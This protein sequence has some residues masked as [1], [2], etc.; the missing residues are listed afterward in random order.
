MDVS[1]VVEIV[2]IVFI[3]SETIVIPMIVVIVITTVPIITLHSVKVVAGMR[4]VNERECI[5]W[6]IG[7]DTKTIPI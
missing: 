2:L 6:N 1:A 4:N 3:G 7:F 5:C